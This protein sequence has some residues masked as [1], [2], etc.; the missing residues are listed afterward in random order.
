MAEE[1]YVND[2]RCIMIMGMIYGINDSVNISHK[3]YNSRT[4]IIISVQKC[5]SWDSVF[6]WINIFCLVVIY[7]KPVHK[8]YFLLSFINTNK[9]VRHWLYHDDACYWTSNLSWGSATSIW[10]SFFVAGLGYFRVEW[11]KRLI[12][13]DL[14]EKIFRI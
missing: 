10:R 8:I 5:Y 4:W 14:R 11:L 2:V 6:L 9:Y 12:S 13:N 7:H 1:Y 3:I